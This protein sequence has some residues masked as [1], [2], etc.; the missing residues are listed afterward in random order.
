MLRDHELN[1]VVASVPLFPAAAFLVLGT[2]WLFVRTPRERTVARLVAA[3]HSAALGAS[4]VVLAAVVARGDRP[5]RVDLGHW[6]TAG[7]YG[8]E[9]TLLIDHLSVAMMVLVSAITGLIGRFS[10]NYLHREPGFFRFFLLLELFATGMLTL[11][12]AGTFD[13]LFVGWELVGLTSALLVAFFHERASTVRAGLRVFVTYRVCDVGLMLGAVLMHQSAH[14]ALFAEAF[15]PAAWPAGAVHFGTGPATLIALCLLLAA[16]GKSALFPVGSW[17]PRAMEGPTPSSALF[18]AALSVHAGAYLLLRA[19]PVL[20]HAPAASI[21]IVVVGAVTALYGTVSWRVQTDAKNALAFATVTQVGLIFVE[22]GLGFYR[23][24]TTHLVA[25][26]CL[27]TF[28]ML[29][30]PSA[31]RDAQ[32]IRAAHAALALPARGVLQ[33]LLPEPALRWLYRLALERFYLDTLQERW[34][35]APVLRLGDFIDRAERRWVA[36]L[37]DWH[38]R[39]PPPVE[40]PT[41][42]PVPSGERPAT[43]SQGVSR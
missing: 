2:L 29:R 10:V 42:A 23:F 8:F 18:Y 31:L 38:V 1:W 34:I 37:S 13:L 17:L 9:L 24:A 40:T 4:L 15:G 35:V 36:A 30:A 6:F 5:W 11:V 12:T 43:R 32:Q 21:V 14:S 33:Q 41:A 25:H 27:R 19:T 16:M 26:A 20:A 22:I 39:T 28:Q 3:A 7:E